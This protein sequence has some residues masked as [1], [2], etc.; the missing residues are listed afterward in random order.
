MFLKNSEANKAEIFAP[1]SE[2]GGPGADLA[3]LKEDGMLPPIYMPS[4]PN[5]R[6]R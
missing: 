1:E 6:R 4:S 2:T 5:L 3:K